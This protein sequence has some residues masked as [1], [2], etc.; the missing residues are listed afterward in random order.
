MNSIISYAI[1]L[2]FGV[3][4]MVS[5]G[6]IILFPLLILWFAMLMYLLMPGKLDLHAVDNVD[7]TIR[8]GHT[9]AL[10]GESGCGKN[11]NR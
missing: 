6:G 9:M 5:G 1:F 3:V 10:V 2:V 7:L 11:D 8:K 4:F